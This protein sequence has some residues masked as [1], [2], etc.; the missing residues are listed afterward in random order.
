MNTS[1]V[2]EP[3]PDHTT[4]PRIE[5]AATDAPVVKHDADH[6]RDR[7]RRGSNTPKFECRLPEDSG[8]GGVKNP[9]K[10]KHATE[11]GLTGAVQQTA[12]DRSGFKTTSSRP[13]AS[14]V[15]H[16]LGGT[17]L[18]AQVMLDSS[19]TAGCHNHNGRR[20]SCGQVRAHQVGTTVEVAKFLIQ[21]VRVGG[22]NHPKYA[23]PITLPSNSFPVKRWATSRSMS[24]WLVFHH[25][26]NCESKLDELVTLP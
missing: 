25:V 22:A 14:D 18:V 8:V 5:F 19:C 2:M 24:C 10:F 3:A 17:E 16:R 26:P 4:S 6:L 12:S 9:P 23:M 7:P 21:A 20:T 15:S 13:K 11:S 1:R